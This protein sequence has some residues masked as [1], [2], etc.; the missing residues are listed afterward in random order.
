M[1]DRLEEVEFLAGD[2]SIADM[3]SFPWV[4]AHERQ[5][6]EMDEFPA[7]TRWFD[8]IAARPAV[9][10]GRNAGAEL[11]QEGA[12]PRTPRPSC[13]ARRRGNRV[14]R[15]RLRKKPKQEEKPL[16]ADFDLDCRGCCGC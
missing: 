7:L 11:R 2:Y 4:V 10:A 9:I 5:G 13:L 12:F 1:D 8:A 14:R 16:H 6:Q 15:L 3:A